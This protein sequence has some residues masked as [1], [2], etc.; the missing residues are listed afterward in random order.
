MTTMRIAIA[1]AS[2]RM[3][4][5]LIRA[6]SEADGMRL[7]IALERQGHAA[8]GT[9]AGVLA[10]LQPNGVAITDDSLAALAASDAVVRFL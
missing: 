9:D 5:T 7:T 4:R 2:G 8:L 3:G 10:G 6:L 1:G